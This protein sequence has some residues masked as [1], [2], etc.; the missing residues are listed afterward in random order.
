MK[1]ET[2]TPA[3]I[4]VI[5]QIEQQ[6]NPY[7]WPRSAFDSSFS[8][9]YLNIK[10]V[11][12]D[13]IIGFIICKIVGDQAEL[14]NICVNPAYQGKGYG[15]QLLQY[16]QTVLQQRIVAEL[17]LEV[18]SSN[19]VANA[20]YQQ[21]GFNCVD[22]RRNYYKNAQGSEDALIMCLYLS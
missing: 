5:H 12:G 16:L 17:W 11:N 10:L 4:S 13:Q 3:D 20:L 8:D 15:K 7:P 19:K 14:F 21:Q 1:F 22:V 9:L 2:L 6:A 18:R